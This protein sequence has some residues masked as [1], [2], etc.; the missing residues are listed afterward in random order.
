MRRREERIAGLK[1]ALGLD[2]GE[3]GFATV[4]GILTTRPEMIREVDRRLDR[5]KMI[6]TKSYQVEPNPGNREPIILEGGVGSF[7][8]AVGLKNPG[9]RIGLEELRAL[10]RSH[11][12]RAL[13]NVSISGSSPEEFEVLAEAFSEVADSI[14]L[15]FSCPHAEPGYGASIGVDPG[16]VY[17]YMKR[18]RESSDLPLLPKLTPNVEDIGSV[19]QA[20]VEGGADG[21]VA[22]N[23]VG[24]EL[25]IEPHSRSPILMNIHGG[26]GG[27][28]GRWVHETAL[29]KIAEVRSAVGPDFPVLGMGGVEDA[30][31]VAAMRRAG[32]DIIGIGSAFA[33]VMP[34]NW[35]AWFDALA[36]GL[37]GELDS[38]ATE[39]EASSRRFF[40]EDAQMEYRPYRITGVEAGIDGLRRI[41]LEGTID[42]EAGQFVFLWL[43][44]VGEKPF[45]IALA[46][47]LTFLVRGRG[48]MTEALCSMEAGETLYV[49]GL[50]GRGARLGTA[51]EAWVLAGGTGLAVVPALARGL[52]EAGKELHILMGIAE[53]EGEDDSVEAKIDESAATRSLF[54]GELSA[55][56]EYRIVPDEGEIGRAVRLFSEEIA[57]VIAEGASPE[58]IALYT[59]GPFPFMQAAVEAA[60]AAGIPASNIQM[61]IETK[62]RCGVGLCGECACAGRLTCREGTFF[63]LDELDARGVSLEECSHDH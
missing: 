54:A 43:P 12:M 62:T 1:R 51:E 25:Y 19:A 47:P 31:S 55:Y 23:T 63:S 14:E 17:R 39:T 33:L 61:S 27:K 37:Y 49:R 15:N 21:L 30:E 8:N 13:L 11:S 34:E 36:K 40:I 48:P 35:E 5:V 4:S 50:Y 41:T 18:V 26:K 28:S 7:G 10:R 38:P 2:R 58:E 9:M 52:K 60:R 3:G 16:L 42:F 56:G 22:I 57:S 6:T 20:A 53:A 59:I 44:G 32:A 46:D 45:S 29:A 24:P